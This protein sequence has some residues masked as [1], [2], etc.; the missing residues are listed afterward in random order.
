MRRAAK[1][2]IGFAGA[3]ATWVTGIFIAS[4]AAR[5]CVAERMRARLSESLDAQVTLADLDLALVRGAVAFEG[6][7]IDRVH[8]GHLHVAVDRIDAGIAPL[9]AYLWDRDLGLVHVDG[10]DVVVDGWGVLRIRPPV[11]PP[12]KMA[13]L[14]I[15][16]AR[17][18]LAP[19]TWAPKWAR[20]AVLIDH[21]ESGE[22]VLRTPLS[23]VFAL[24]R[25][26][27]RLEVPGTAPVALHYERGRLDAS[28]SIFGP[29]PI[30]IPVLLPAPEPGH[31][32]QQLVA[33]GKDVAERL[34]LARA[35][36]WIMDELGP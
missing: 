25:L 30:S 32:G 3:G 28:G 19:A 5:G 17:L 20:F 8:D 29:D 34:A 27:A 22:T 10:V 4:F 26:D 14:A 1:V 15:D 16:D 23:W 9:G 11:R 31:E 21:A 13:S 36:G 7:V 18:E 12:I 2:A 6:L 33:L 24:E 35:S